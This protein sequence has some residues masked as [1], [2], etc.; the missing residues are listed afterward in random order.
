MIFLNLFFIFFIVPVSGEKLQ[1]LQFS[2][3][4]TLKVEVARTEKEKAK[5]L[6]EKTSL[7]ENQG[8]LFI[9]KKPQKLFF[10]TKKT[11][12]SLSIGFFDKDYVLKEIHFM[13]PQNMMK[14]NS[15]V[16]TYQSSCQ[17]QYAIEVNREWFLR[18]KVKI[19]DRFSIQKPKEKT[20]AYKK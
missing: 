10:W 1:T 19:G 4:S 9:F 13:E 17:C 11:Y 7:P 3:G 18:N 8:M 12:L 2:N 15:K 6:M 14:L 5:G 16:N 20:K